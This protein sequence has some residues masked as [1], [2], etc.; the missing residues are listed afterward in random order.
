MVCPHC[1]LLRHCASVTRWAQRCERN[2]NFEQR[3][4]ESGAWWV[5]RASPD[6]GGG[7]PPRNTWEASLHPRLVMAWLG[8]VSPDTIGLIF[9]CPSWLLSCVITVMPSLDITGSLIM[10]RPLLPGLAGDGGQWPGLGRIMQKCSDYNPR[11]PETRWEREE[12]ERGFPHRHNTHG[13]GTLLYQEIYQIES[14]ARVVLADI[15]G[16]HEALI[17]VWLSPPDSTRLDVSECRGD[18]LIVHIL[19]PTF[20]R[21]RISLGQWSHHG[22]TPQ[23]GSVKQNKSAR[24]PPGPSRRCNHGW[25]IFWPPYIYICMW[26]G[27]RPGEGGGPLDWRLLNWTF[28]TQHSIFQFASNILYFCGNTRME[29]LYSLQTNSK[30][31]TPYIPSLVCI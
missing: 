24:T 13:A 2:F 14:Q 5:M 9:W 7:R 23:W 3:L 4:S 22:H 21:C 27:A 18:G 29:P 31:H 19:L 25:R 26:T 11:T 17:T 6:P 10:P 16:V 1:A 15:P 28:Q 30:S 8:P 20:L 12:R